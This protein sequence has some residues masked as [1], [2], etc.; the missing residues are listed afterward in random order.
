MLD[1][2]FR[3]AVDRKTEPIGKLIAGAGISPDILTGFGV[4][5]SVAAAVWIGT[6]RLVVG[7]LF[8]IM[9]SIPDLLDGPVAKAAQAVSKRGAFFDSVGDRV[10]DFALFSGLAAYFMFHGSRTMAVV[11]MITFGLAALVSY[12]R[13]KAE[14]LGFQAKG[15]LMERAE[16]LVI[17]IAGILI[18]FLLIPAVLT[19]TLG[20]AVTVIQRFVKIWRQASSQPDRMQAASRLT[21]LRRVNRRRRSRY[22]N[23]RSILDEYTSA[24]GKRR[25]TGGNRYHS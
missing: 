6:G 10:S 11:T 12:Q 1:G 25:R 18:S 21:S 13:A 14:S 20:S 2:N 4:L 8:L 24:T 5:M 17:L 16:R 9:G 15:G 7:G 19:V 22:R 23:W 3:A